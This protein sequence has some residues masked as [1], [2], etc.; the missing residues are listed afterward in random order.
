MKD[1]L[2]VEGDE[3]GLQVEVVDGG[4][5]GVGVEVAEMPGELGEF[6]GGGGVAGGDGED[7]GAEF[8]VVGEVAVAQEFEARWRGFVAGT[9]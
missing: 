7:L 9:V 3:L 1:G 8:F 2:A 4:L 6:G 5:D